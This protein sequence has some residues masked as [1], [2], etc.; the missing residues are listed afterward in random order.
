MGKLIDFY[1]GKDI[2]PEGFTIHEVFGWGDRALEHEHTHIHWLLPS[3]NAVSSAILHRGPPWLG[4]S[5]RRR[6]FKP[7]DQRIG[8]MGGC[9][10][11]L[12]DDVGRDKGRK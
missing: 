9:T 2:H 10:R 1:L 11:R 7:L 4:R 6:R 12:K 3:A 5:S 8:A